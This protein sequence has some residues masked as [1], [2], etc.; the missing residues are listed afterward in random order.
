MDLAGGVAAAAVTRDLPGGPVPV[1]SLEAGREIARLCGVAARDVDECA[2]RQGVWPERHLR[3]HAACTVVEQ[4]RLLTACAAVVGLGGLGG[5][6]LELL[7]RAGVGHIRACD[8][9]RFEAT[10][11][12][13]QLLSTEDGLGGSK[14][15]AA[16]SRLARI[17]SSV[18]ADV[19]DVFLDEAGMRELLHGADLAVDCLGGLA[20]RK[21]LQDAARDVGIPLVTAAMAGL[22]AFV[23]TVLPGAAGP[24]DFLGGAG[25]PSGEDILGTPPESV[26]VAAA[27]QGA[28]CLRLLRGRTSAL[29]GRMLVVDLR[30]M[31]FETLSLG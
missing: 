28:E 30:S 12:N 18:E 23:A 9:D 4:L 29:D 19:R 26:A 22:T 3:N 1:L 10:N 14:A 17:N 15:E 6:V 11:L 7:A 31:A 8:G 25:Q 2:L 27:F 16:R 20:Q 21:A 5:H 13:R 24:A